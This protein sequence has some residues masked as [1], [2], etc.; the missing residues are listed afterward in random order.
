MVKKKKTVK[1]TIEGK[2]I[3]LYF[4]RKPDPQSPPSGK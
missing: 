2:W 1:K 3:F 4:L